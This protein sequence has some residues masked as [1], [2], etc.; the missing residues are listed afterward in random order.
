MESVS[1]KMNRIAFLIYS[2]H[3]GGAERMVCRLASFFASHGICVS[4]FLFDDSEIAY[5]LHEKV[6]ILKCEPGDKTRINKYMYSCK[7]IREQVKERSI[8]AIIAFTITMVPYAVISTLFTK[9][10]VIGAERANPKHY[11]KKSEFIKNTFAGFC[12]GYIFQTK[13]AC[14]CYPLWVRKKAEI[15]GNIA[16]GETVNQQVRK[17]KKWICSAGRLHKDKDYCT[18]LKAMKKVLHF[19]PDAQL[20]IYGDGPLRNELENIAFDLGIYNNVHFCG[21]TKELTE[22]MKK[23]SIFAFSSRSEGMPNALIEAMSLGLPCVATDCEFGP[24]DLIENG[25]NGFL[26]PVG[27]D[28]K[29]AERLIQLL[30]DDNLRAHIG[31]K[32]E[33]IIVTNSEE[34]ISRKYSNYISKIIS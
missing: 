30:K 4:I 2:L 15:I 22:E 13:G 26:V 14:D 10:K 28:E 25:V 34:V 20:N 9:C 16:P 29:M 33:K 1:V 32:A 5:P 11:G 31:S 24:S 3:G 8:E 27:D 19:I 17:E 21:F 12:N 6:N 23:N 7:Y 18:L